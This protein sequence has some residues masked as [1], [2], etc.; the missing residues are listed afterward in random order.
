MSIETI[1]TG[2]QLMDSQLL[3][4]KR[5][6]D[7][8]VEKMAKQISK[9]K[10]QRG[11]SG[12]QY[13][14]AML[15]HGLAKFAA[16]ITEYMEADVGRGGR[17]GSARLLLTGGDASVIG[18]VFMKFIINGI[19]IKYGTLQSI[20]KKAAEQVEDEFR[21]A[22]LRKQDAKLWKRLVDASSRKEG[23]WKRTIIINA[24]NDETSKGT[25]NNW[26]SW[27]QAQLMHLGS[28]L[29]T[30]LIETVGLVQITTESKGKHNTVKRLVATP[31]TLDWI[32]E[33]CS[34][35]GLTAPQYKPLVIQPR[36]WNYEN[37]TGGVYYSHYCRPVRFVK[38]HNNN[39]MADLKHT[40]IDVVL[41][42]VNAMQRTAW[43]V[44]KDILNLVN[45]MWDNGVEWCDSIPPRFNEEPAKEEDF[46]LETKQQWAAYY[47]EKNRIE[48][49][50]R[51]SAAKRI[52][53]SSTMSTAQ[54]F[55]EYDEF[56]FGYNLD[57]RG[58]V[59][60]VS[61]YN[62]M[63]P[64]EMKATLRFAN[65]KPL[66]ESGWR[67]LAIHL[68]NTGAFDKIDKDTLEARVQWVMD[69]EHWIIQCVENPFENRQWCDADKPLQFM[70]AAMEW[71]GFL[72]QGDAFVSH[73][74]IALDGSA[75]GLQHLSMATQCASTALNV[76]LL[77]VDKPMD[78]YQIVADKVVVQLR[79]DSEQSHEHWGAPILNNMGVRVPNYTE[80]AL[81]WLKHGFGRVHAKRSCM[82]YSYGSKQYG[83]KEQIQSD[84]MH[85][86]MRDCN[87]TGKDFPFSY[88]NGY[89]ASSYI[90]R[91]LWDAV[92]D[93]VKRPAHLMD[94]LTDAAS[95][96]AKEKFQ[97]PDGSHHAMPVRW[98]TPLGFPVVQS[99][100]DTNPR[101]VK[102]SINGNLVYLTLKESTDQ[103]CTRKS[104]QAM[105]P[106]WV[107]GCDAA[108]LQ[109]TVS[110]AAE[111]E[112][113]INSF[114]LIHDSFATH[115]ADTDEFWHIIRE[116]MVEMYEA[117][118]IVHG[119]YLELNAQMKPENREEIKLPPSKGTLDLAATVS[120]RYSFA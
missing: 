115:A 65:G 83:F 40:N 101:R 84:V 16:G 46:E 116:S 27:S 21:L 102:T 114:S 28:K 47:K 14:Q 33:R 68:A 25:I 61:A 55:S 89:R 36:D 96:V 81:E 74:P 26:E 30:I 95:K 49:S 62:G 77:P 67:W 111:S 43:S 91:L 106:N 20:I 59:Y 70:A 10:T 12:T 11:E 53:F 109:L 113:G 54:E 97:M 118:D 63:G 5:M 9:Q 56:F 94:W 8:G 105:A 45:E 72:E 6:R 99:Y 85:P 13:G 112:Q 23:H 108:H 120:A 71:Q 98:T 7:V 3:I 66:G 90:A 19:S 79:K 48:A 35:I 38:T 75:S 110:R 37:L 92:V 87:K 39:Y 93:S 86:L 52:A 69:N 51:E 17:G 82:T 58:R 73:L 24:M 22:D 41:H 119:L 80:L 100:Y 18:F 31:E 76:N 50:N 15:T 64:D 2:D 29:L 88:D 107:H 1:I 57:F 78:L 104:A 117:G 44:N 60:A 32:D 42:A 103:I 34:R 4:E